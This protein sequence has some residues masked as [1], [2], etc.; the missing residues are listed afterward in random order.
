MITTSHPHP[1]VRHP[2]PGRA[3]AHLLVGSPH[4]WRE[5]CEA[6]RAVDY[7]NPD[8][9][10]ALNGVAIRMATIV[11]TT[12]SSL[13]SAAASSRQPSSELRRG[14]AT[15][16]PIMPEHIRRLIP[17]DTEG[18]DPCLRFHASGMC[19][20][21][22]AELCAN[23]RRV[24]HWVGRL[25]RELQDFIDRNYDSERRLQPSSPRL[26]RP[27]RYPLVG[28]SVHTHYLRK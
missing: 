26:K 2:V 13:H 21:G 6:V 1:V 14:P 3:L 22:S 12:S 11:P 28:T 18:R 15:R 17:R 25:P 27:R 7:H 20:G 19:Y 16:T 24:H 10:A 5:F 9:Q 23:H 4:W 8:W